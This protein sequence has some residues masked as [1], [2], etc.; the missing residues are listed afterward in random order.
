M[1]IESKNFIKNFKNLNPTLENFPVLTTKE[2]KTELL[3][4]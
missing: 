4:F 1:I 3:Y 2:N